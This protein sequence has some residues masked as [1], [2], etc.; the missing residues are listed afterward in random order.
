MTLPFTAMANP[1]YQAMRR[2]GWGKEYN[3]ALLGV[4]EDLLDCQSGS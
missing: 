1:I 3:S 2:K 4:I